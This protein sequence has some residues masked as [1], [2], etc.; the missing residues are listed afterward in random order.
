MSERPTYSKH[1]TWKF[2]SAEMF[3]LMFLKGKPAVDTNITKESTN[4]L[5]CPTPKK[6]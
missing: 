5:P 3:K 2:L 4:I 6:N 1:P